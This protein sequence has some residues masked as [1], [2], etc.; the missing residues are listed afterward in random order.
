MLQEAKIN[1]HHI[2]CTRL[3]LEPLFLYS[4]QRR[5]R[6]RLGDPQR[7]PACLG[8]PHPPPAAPAAGGWVIPRSALRRVNRKLLG[9]AVVAGWPASSFWSPAAPPPR[10]RPRRCPRAAGAS[11]FCRRFLRLQRQF[12]DECAG[13]RWWWCEAAAVRGSGVQAVDLATSGEVG[14]CWP[15]IRRGRCLGRVPGRRTISAF[16]SSST[17]LVVDAA[18]L[19]LRAWSSSAPGCRSPA[20]CFLRRLR[21]WRSSWLRFLEAE[22]GVSQQCCSLYPP[23]F[24]FACIWTCNV[25]LYV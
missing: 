1:H 8:I 25:F 19:R 18:L 4:A 13:G 22:D 12:G 2:K 6:R 5:T 11:P 15:Q 17:E 9:G 23:C 21:R 10:R 3:F 20:S 24:F 16:R 7:L 14:R